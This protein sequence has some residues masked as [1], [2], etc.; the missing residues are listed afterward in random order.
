M[1]I[2]KPACEHDSDVIFRWRTDKLTREMFLTTD[3]VAWDGHEKWFANTLKSNTRLLLMCIDTVT[4]EKICV[5]RFD[6]DMNRA[7]VSI[8]LAP[9]MRGK[10]LAK[11]CLNETI[12]FLKTHTPKI[13]TLDAEIKRKNLA[14]IA[15]FQGVGFSQVG[16]ELSLLRFQYKI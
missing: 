3:L 12:S 7:L 16:E 15:T 14:S 9:S 10:G 8:N 4:N 1:I 6:L 13:D 5:V 2:V 11:R